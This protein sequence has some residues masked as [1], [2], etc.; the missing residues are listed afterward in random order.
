L[1][2]RGSEFTEC[3][4]FLSDGA[5][6]ATAQVKPSLPTSFRKTP[7]FSKEGQ[8]T[9]QKVKIEEVQKEYGKRSPQVASAY[10]KLGLYYSRNLEKDRKEHS[11]IFE[12]Q[13]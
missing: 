4:G 2:T 13:I 9:R 5:E 11:P 3:R 8:I 12:Y 10:K 1:E 7:D 6:I